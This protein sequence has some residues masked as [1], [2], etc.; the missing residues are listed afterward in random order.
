[1]RQLV[2]KQPELVISLEVIGIEPTYARALCRQLRDER[3]RA[4][5]YSWRKVLLFKRTS[6]CLKNGAARIIRVIL[7]LP[8]S[9]EAWHFEALL[10]CRHFYN[11]ETPSEAVSTETAINRKHPDPTPPF[12]YPRPLPP[13]SW[14]CDT[15][16]LLFLLQSVKSPLA[17]DFVIVNIYPT[18]FPV[19][20]RRRR[21]KRSMVQK[22]KNMGSNPSI[23][24]CMSHL[25]HIVRHSAPPSADTHIHTR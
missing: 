8:R 14:G 21:T 16:V 18:L 11:T 23:Q 25:R 12:H 20:A 6:I 17:F 13:I 4:C 10:P 9:Y 2:S 24:I 1:M 3:T 22:K 15:A 5:F 7:R 19:A